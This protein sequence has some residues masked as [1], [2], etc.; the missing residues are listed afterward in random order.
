MPNNRDTII[1][2]T[3]TAER[4]LRDRGARGRDLEEMVRDLVD[5]EVVPKEMLRRTAIANRIRNLISNSSASLQPV[6]MHQWS[7]TMN[8][9]VEWLESTSGREK[10]TTNKIVFEK[11]QAPD[12]DHV[13][14]PWSFEPWML[15]SIL[16]P[17]AVLV[18]AI[19]HHHAA[20]MPPPIQIEQSADS[21]AHS[22]AAMR[23]SEAAPTIGGA[24]SLRPDRRRHGA[25]VHAAR[26]VVGAP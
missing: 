2:G 23:R 9:L 15:I 17:L 6:E 18:G 13:R 26:A 16:V 19:M 5:R 4:L 21:A 11:A 25:P 3:C 24:S 12:A 20:L 1:D 7:E 8:R 10:S 22:D 14:P